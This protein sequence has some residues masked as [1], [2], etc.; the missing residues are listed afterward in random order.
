MSGTFPQSPGPTRLTV[1]S[2]QPLL[3]SVAHSLKRQVRSRG[4]Q[5]W[6]FTVEFP[7]ML[8]DQLAPVLAFVLAQRGGYETFTFYHP[9]D[10]TPRGS[11]SGT[12]LVNGGSQT[13][14]SVAVDGFASYGTVKAGD[15]VKFGGSNKVYIVTA[16]VTADEYGV[17]TLPIEPALVASPANNASI[18]H[19]A[20]PFT[21]ALAADSIETAV[22]PGK[23]YSLTVEL[24]EVP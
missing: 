1:R 13:G 11:W 9:L 2:V 4:G 16:D 3:V 12:P 18:T 20:V 15:W 22:V 19:T 14:R 23:V 21:C 7:P 17:M 8:R 24:V 10:T 6:G 5:R